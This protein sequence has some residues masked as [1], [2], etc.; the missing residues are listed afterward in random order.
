VQQEIPM[1]PWSPASA[2]DGHLLE[3]CDRMDVVKERAALQ[4]GTSPLFYVSLRKPNPDF[5]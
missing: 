2:G 3:H 5:I 4:K 1:R